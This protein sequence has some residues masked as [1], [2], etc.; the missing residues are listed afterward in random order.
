[1]KLYDIFVDS[2]ICGIEAPGHITMEEYFAKYRNIGRSEID[3]NQTKAFMDA[4][5]T[6]NFPGVPK[7]L[8][9]N[10]VNIVTQLIIHAYLIS[11]RL[12]EWMAAVIFDHDDD[13]LPILNTVLRMRDILTERI[14]RQAEYVPAAMMYIYSETVDTKY[15]PYL[16]KISDMFEKH[17]L[18]GIHTCWPLIMLKMKRLREFHQ[19]YYQVK[20]G[21]YKGDE[22]SMMDFL[23]FEELLALEN[24]HK[25]KSNPVKYQISRYEENDYSCQDAYGY[26]RVLDNTIRVNHKNTQSNLIENILLAKTKGA[27]YPTDLRDRLTDNFNKL[28]QVDEIS[29]LFNHVVRQN[30]QTKTHE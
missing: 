23:E 14:R 30:W 7:D 24:L 29:S 18:N 10:K 11:S 5:Y 26:M 20:S 25:L 22:N 4:L 3:I 12:K 28:P 19:Q 1:M 27:E 13:R 2:A 17:E 21:K 15:A 9:A 8:D 16:I 6:F